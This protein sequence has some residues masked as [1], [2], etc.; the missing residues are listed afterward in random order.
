MHP[1][2]YDGLTRFSRPYPPRPE[3]LKLNSFKASIPLCGSRLTG[4]GKLP[5]RALREFLPFTP[6]SLK[7]KTGVALEVNGFLDRFIGV[8]QKIKIFL[9]VPDN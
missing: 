1:T 7:G 4:P 3:N 6:L 2:W 8:G 5:I 9:R